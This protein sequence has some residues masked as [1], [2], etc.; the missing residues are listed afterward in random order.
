MLLWVRQVFPIVI[1]DVVKLMQS[2]ALLD[3]NLN[4]SVNA[5]SISYSVTYCIL[6]ATC[7]ANLRGVLNRAFR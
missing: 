1:G 6:T 2:D 5:R 4:R 7:F 3:S